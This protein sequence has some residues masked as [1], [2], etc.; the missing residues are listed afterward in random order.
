MSPLASNKPGDA[1]LPL[2][3]TH[4]T[5]PCALFVSH[6]VSVPSPALQPTGGRRP[7]HPLFT[8]LFLKLKI[9][10]IFVQLIIFERDY[11]FFYWHLALDI[12]FSFLFVQLPFVSNLYIP[13]QL[14]QG[15][16]FLPNNLGYQIHSVPSKQKINKM[17]SFTTYLYVGCWREVICLQS[18]GICYFDFKVQKK[19]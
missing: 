19:K 8:C 12:N 2:N 6:L 11:Y 17:C 14:N 5:G 4:R 3:L 13:S 10:H 1:L 9:K 16:S 15:Y 18:L 7:L